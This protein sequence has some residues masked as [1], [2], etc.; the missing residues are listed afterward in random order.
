MDT[1][2]SLQILLGL[3]ALSLLALT[4]AL[5]ALL[6]QRWRADTWPRWAGR[7]RRL[8]LAPPAL[9]FLVLA[10]PVVAWWLLHLQ[11]VPLGETWVLAGACLYLLAGIAWLLLATRLWALG[12]GAAQAAHAL[13]VA[14]GSAVAALVLQVVILGLM[15]VQP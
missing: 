8:R 7:A 10:A 4:G 5:A 11:A 9:L 12:N 14:F 6:W 13:P 3:L 15:A 1:V 2:L